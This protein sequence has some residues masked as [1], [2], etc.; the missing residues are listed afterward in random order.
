MIYKK[1]IK[2]IFLHLRRRTKSLHLPF[3]FTKA[4]IYVKILLV[5]NFLVLWNECIYFH[6]FIIYNGAIIIYIEFIFLLE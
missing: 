6:A 4:C 3:S 5:I 2:M 1:K